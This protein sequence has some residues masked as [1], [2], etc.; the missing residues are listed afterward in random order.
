MD[1]VRGGFVELSATLNPSIFG[2]QAIGL[3]AEEQQAV[4]HRFSRRHT[5]THC[6][7]KALFR[8]NKVVRRLDHNHGVRIVSSYIGE[9][10]EN[11]GRRCSVGE[12]ACG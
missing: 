7:Q 5:L 1:R 8:K 3:D 12:S 9:W 11:A 6:L 4:R 2:F 10:E